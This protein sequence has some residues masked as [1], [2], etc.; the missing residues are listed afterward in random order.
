MNARSTWQSGPDAAHRPMSRRRADAW[1]QVCNDVERRYAEAE[2]R[3]PRPYGF[4]RFSQ[5]Q[6]Q[7]AYKAEKRTQ[8]EYALQLQ[9]LRELEGHLYVGVAYDLSQM[10]FVG[11]SGSD[12]IR[13]IYCDPCSFFDAHGCFLGPDESGLE[14][15]FLPRTV[16]QERDFLYLY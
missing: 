12:G 16:R 4:Q 11:W 10:F 14:P 7:C 8:A 9:V 2:G 15:L 6:L 13:H 3:K 1:R 5:G